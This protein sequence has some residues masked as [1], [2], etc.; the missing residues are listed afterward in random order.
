MKL[1]V[2]ADSE[3][4]RLGLE[5]ARALGATVTVMESDDTRGKGET[6][7]AE[8]RAE[9]IETSLVRRAMSWLNALRSTTQ[10]E[11]YDLVLVGKMWQRGLPALLFGSV[12][13]RLLAEI[14]T[15]LLIAQW[16]REKVQRCLVAIGGGPSSRQVGNWAG[17]IAKGFRAQIT[18]FHVT[19]RPPGMF[20][21]LTAMEESLK[22]FLALDT[23]EAQGVQ[24]AAQAARE[25]GIEPELKLAYGLVADQVLAEAQANNYDLI[26]LGSS[27]NAPASTRLVMEGVT[28]RVVQRAPVPTLIVRGE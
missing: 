5:F 14:S 9:G 2:H 27:Y 1:L 17:L 20:T 3:S 19:E 11:K 22:E 18:V 13:P 4:A 10:A 21:G 8:F 16:W 12:P 25:A 7:A 24:Y 23:Q 26:V 15:N 28:M 6:F